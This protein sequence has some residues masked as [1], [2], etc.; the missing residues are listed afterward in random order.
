[1]IHAD[2]STNDVHLSEWSTP[3]YGPL[4]DIEVDNEP[5]SFNHCSKTLQMSD[6][7]DSDRVINMTHF[8]AN[9]TNLKVAAK[10][11]ISIQTVVC[12]ISSRVN[13][14]GRRIVAMLDSG[15][16]TY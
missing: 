1:M 12:S 3:V 14:T 16:Y 5:D 8:Q 4:P 6:I 13:K 10:N 2:K 15:Y 7:S 9:M 11:A